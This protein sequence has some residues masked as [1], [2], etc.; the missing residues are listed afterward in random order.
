MGTPLEADLSSIIALF[1]LLLSAVLLWWF[2]LRVRQG[3]R[4]AFRPIAAFDVLKS[5]LLSVAETGKRVHV[6]LGNVK[7]GGDQTAIAS[8]GLTVLDYLAEQGASM[9]ISPVVTVSD[10]TML[11][12][13]Q[14]VLYRAYARKGR[15]RHFRSTAAQFIASDPAAY[16]VGVQSVL[17]D[18]RVAANVMVGQYGDEYLLMGETG[19]QRDLVQVTGS[20]TITSQPFMVATTEYALVGEEAFAAGAY[21]GDDPMQAASLRVQDVLRIIAVVAIVAGAIAKTVLGW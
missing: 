21:L 17:D 15:A 9:G 16:A 12:A 19:A 2:G 7:L 18:D 4:Y 8:A 13:S 10:P 6:S 5:L 14:D 11:M 3:T 1:A 20:N